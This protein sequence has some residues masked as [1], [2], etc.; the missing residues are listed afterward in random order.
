MTV[1]NLVQANARCERLERERERWRDQWAAQQ[2]AINISTGG[3]TL[4][5]AECAALRKAMARLHHP[6]TG[7]DAERLKTW[8]TLLDSLERQAERGWS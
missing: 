5:P 1:Q 3:L 4:T 2:G 8:N 6:D 7:G